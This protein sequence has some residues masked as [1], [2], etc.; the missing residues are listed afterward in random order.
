M[1]GFGGCVPITVAEI[2]G[3]EQSPMS[4]ASLS[5]L[6]CIDSAYGLDW[7]TWRLVHFFVFKLDQKMC[8]SYYWSHFSAPQEG[9]CSPGSWRR[10]FIR[11]INHRFPQTPWMTPF[12]CFL[13]F[14]S[15]PG[16][17]PNRLRWEELH[18][19]ILTHDTHSC[20]WMF[21]RLWT[22]HLCM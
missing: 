3:F 7:L 15:Y 19:F 11:S 21:W 12:L 2:C 13:T 14:S 6:H 16:T 18:P 5:T 17:H 1:V 8:S 10:D 20:L 22:L 9:Q 4:Q